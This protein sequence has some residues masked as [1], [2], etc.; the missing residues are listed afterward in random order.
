MPWHYHFQ[1]RLVV[2]TKDLFLFP[3]ILTKT[4]DEHFQSRIR[5]PD[6]QPKNKRV[7][8]P[9]LNGRK[10]NSCGGVGDG[11]G[12]YGERTNIRP[13]VATVQFE[14][15]QLRAFNFHLPKACRRRGA[16]CL[17]MGL[18]INLAQIIH[19]LLPT[20]LLIKLAVVENLIWFQ[21]L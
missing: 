7:Y 11:V 10:T 3:V 16:R 14:N 4:K 6:L 2:K 5:R 1:S 8:K 15:T 20:Q 21:F 13:V 9:G 18:L 17:C 12:L 19:D